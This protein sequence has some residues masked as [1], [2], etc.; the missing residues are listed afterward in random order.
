[1]GHA[2][3]HVLRQSL[4]A[5]RLAER[6]GLD[7]D[8]RA[9]VYYVSLLSWVGC[10]V[11]AYEQAKWFGDELALK[12]DIRHVD[13]G[14]PLPAAAFLLTHL[15][16]GRPVL[17]RARVGLAFVG[18][19]GRRAAHAMLENH[20]LATNDLAAAPRGRH[21]HR[22]PCEGNRRAAPRRGRHPRSWPEVVSRSGL[23]ARRTS[24]F[25]RRL[26]RG[27]PGVLD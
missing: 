23:S 3:E 13:F 7:D 14:R 2:M 24:A 4:I 19:G 8:E 26:E 6:L 16:S 25:T 22:P 17:E 18:E 20:W 1:M 5:L 27:V 11:D 15:G 9:V 21:H 12:R 10:H